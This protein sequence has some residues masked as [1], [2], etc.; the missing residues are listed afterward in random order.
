MKTLAYRLALLSVFLALP[1]LTGCSADAEYVK[2][3]RAT[4]EALA[5]A[6]AAHALTLADDDKAR[7]L[8]TLATWELRI[9]KAEGK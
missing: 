5:P 3:D 1:V 9:R 8:R 4:Y 2:A 6:V 7:E